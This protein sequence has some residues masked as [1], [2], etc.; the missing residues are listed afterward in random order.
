MKLS[1]WSLLGL[2]IVTF[3]TPG[4]LPAQATEPN[5]NAVS[6]AIQDNP[7]TLV[8]DARDADRGL[9]TADKNITHPVL[10]NDGIA[11]LR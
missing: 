3:L 11:R 4:L 7:E 6:Y 9:M 5:A 8:L 2:G 1:S 10:D